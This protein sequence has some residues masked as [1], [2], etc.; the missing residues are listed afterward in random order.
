MSKHKKIALG[1]TFDH[2]HKGHQLFL[3]FAAELAEQ[4]VIGVTTE[5][6]IKSKVMVEAIEPFEVRAEAVKAFCRSLPLKNKVDV[7]PLTD[8]YGPTVFNTSIEALAV[9]TN[10]ES[11]ARMINK[12]RAEIGLAQLPVYVRELEAAEDNS[13]ISS[14]RIRL[15]QLNRNGRVYKK[16]LE[17]GLVLTQKQRRFFSAPQGEIVTNPS[18]AKLTI[19]VGDTSLETFHHNHWPYNLGIVDLIKE[20]KSY[21]PP[22]I[23]KE[24]FTIQAPNPPGVITRETVAALEKCLVEQHKHLLINGEEDLVA[25]AAM[26]LSPLGVK[27]YYGQPQQGIVES[28]VTEANKEAFASILSEK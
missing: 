15:G 2:F 7:V 1:G 9:T 3:L 16:I 5:V 17:N 28:S 23:S 10:T 24:E 27:I 12:K 6:M 20:R 19:V 4:L 13:I 25:V 26:L 22:V 18:F 21:S 11:G 14:E 8:P